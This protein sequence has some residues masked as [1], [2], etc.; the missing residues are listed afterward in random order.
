M[1]K[2]IN[3][4]SVGIMISLLA[5]SGCAS[6]QSTAAGTVVE[7]VAADDTE[8][9][10]S[11][12]METAVTET[13]KEDVTTEESKEGAE[14][15]VLTEVSDAQER[16]APVRIWGVVTETGDNFIT[17]DNQSKVSSP[18]EIV[19]MIDPESTYVLD[20]VNGLPVA[21]DEVQT[22]NFQAYLGPAM[23]LSLPPQAVPY[24]VI[25]NIP[26][27][28]AAPLYVIASGPMTEKDGAQVLTGNDGTEYQ[29]AGDAR[30]QPFL[31]KNIVR[32]ED[33]REGSECLVW[34]DTE[35]KIERMVLL[36]SADGGE[37]GKADETTS[38]TIEGEDVSAQVVD[39]GSLILDLPSN[40]TTGYTW[41][42]VEE[43]D[44]FASDYNVYIEPDKDGQVVGKGGI[45]EF[46]II[47]LDEGVGTM[48]FQYRRNWDGGEIAGTYE[49]TLDISRENKTYLRINSVSFRQLAKES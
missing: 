41:V 12:V 23:T 43:P 8:A 42:I 3:L 47:A 45:A 36:T 28:A 17:V 46:H 32:M 1:K 26:E 27:D 35:G 44:N 40:A 5:M 11:G 38:Y 31:T 29:L 33:V 9:D 34:L 39:G 37:D 2:N 16:M 10:S 18:G 4:L 19:L 13:G 6:G 25:V 22:G 20:G 24:M 21:L 7:S 14:A 15:S 48:L 49:L 30:I